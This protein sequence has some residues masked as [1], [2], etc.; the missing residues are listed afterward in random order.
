MYHNQT[1]LCYSNV[2]CNEHGT[3]FPMFFSQ[4][5]FFVLINELVYYSCSRSLTHNSRNNSPFSHNYKHNLKTTHQLVQIISLFVYFYYF[6][7]SRNVL[8]SDTVSDYLFM[9][10]YY[11]QKSR[12][13]MFSGTVS[14]YLFIYVFLLFPEMLFSGTVHFA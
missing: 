6:Q 10:F 11:F 7:K 8:F 9:Y 12:N 14:D 3:K 5:V 2:Y 13:V 4:S 1:S